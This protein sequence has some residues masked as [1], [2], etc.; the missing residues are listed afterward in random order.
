[1]RWPSPERQRNDRYIMTDI[2][3]DKFRD[4]LIRLQERYNDY[5]EH[6]E[7]K[8]FL[9]ESVK[10]SCIQRFEICFDTSWKH[11]KK[12]LKEEL[13]LSDIQDSPN[14]VFR[15]AEANKLISD[16]ELW[17]QFNKKRGDTTHDY[18]GDKA[19]ETF[20]IIHTF[21]KEA[22]ESFEKMSGEKWQNKPQ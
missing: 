13:G 1:M 3:Y 11:L 14:P 18:C 17:I 7:L 4:S 20:A 12:H 8:G 16:A 10:E 15:K 21:I 22:I 5:L 2:N 19:E 9:A 6:R